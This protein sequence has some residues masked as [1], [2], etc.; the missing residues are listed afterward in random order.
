VKTLSDMVGR[1]QVSGGNSPLDQRTDFMM[2]RRV[3]PGES[4]KAKLLTCEGNHAAEYQP[5]TSDHLIRGLVDRLPQ[6]DAIWPL[7]DRVKWL[8]TAVG[9]FDLVYKAGDDEHRE[10]SIA[11]VK[12]EAAHRQ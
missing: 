12:Q 11:F 4:L 10:I 7:D 2:M 8:R 5:A 1:S 6:P 3:E 9:I